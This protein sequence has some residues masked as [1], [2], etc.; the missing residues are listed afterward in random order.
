MSRSATAAP[1]SLAIRG[2][3]E[4]HDGMRAYVLD[5]RLTGYDSYRTARLIVADRP[6]LRVRVLTLDDLTVLCP[7]PEQRELPDRWEGTL[8]LPATSRGS[9][10]PADLTRALVEAGIEPTALDDA[11]RRHLIGFVAE[12]RPGPTRD[13]RL[14]A[15]VSA[16]RRDQVRVRG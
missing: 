11:Q 13:A 6:P 14:A 16:A 9:V 10:M 1:E 15:A 3:R 4:D 8:E 7:L 12:A 5:R 2:H